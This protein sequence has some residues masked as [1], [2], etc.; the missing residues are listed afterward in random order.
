MISLGTILTRGDDD[1]K[2]AG[3]CYVGERYYM[4]V[5]VSNENVVAMVPAV[6]IEPPSS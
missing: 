4:L 5:L 6:E 2:V 1:Y 3:I